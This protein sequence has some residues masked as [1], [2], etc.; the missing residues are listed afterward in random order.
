VY[1]VIDTIAY[2]NDLL[3]RYP[4]FTERGEGL[5]VILD[6]EEIKEPPA[7]KGQAVTVQRPDGSV[8]RL[9]VDDVECPHLAVGLFF[10]SASKESIPRGTLIDW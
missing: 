8:A 2:S 3:R 9:I 6:P 5:L 7:I 1:R 4:Q 10:K